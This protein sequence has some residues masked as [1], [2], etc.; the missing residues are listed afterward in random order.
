MMDRSVIA[1]FQLFCNAGDI[2]IREP[3]NREP[4][5]IIFNIQL[6]GRGVETKQSVRRS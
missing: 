2:I 5:N 1:G 6:S 4:E 3:E